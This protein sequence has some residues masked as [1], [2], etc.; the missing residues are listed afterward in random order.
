[1]G[2]GATPAAHLTDGVVVG[3]VL[4]IRA[5]AERGALHEVRR[6]LA[7]W[8]AWQGLGAHV[9]VDLQLAVG[10]AVTNGVEHAYGPGR[11]GPVEVELR[12]TADCVAV[13]VSD[14]GRWRPATA[15]TGFRGRGLRM[16]RAL[17][18]GVEID[19]GAGGTRVRFEV[20][21]PQP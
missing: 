11:G 8:A 1:M 4:R 12:R 3:S 13:Q 2:G 18:R 9:V 19:P 21:L 17:A 6:R 14:R 10:E 20:P 15:S 7:R 16:I 5:R